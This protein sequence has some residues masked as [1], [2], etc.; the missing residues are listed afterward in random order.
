MGDWVLVGMRSEL[1]PGEYRVVWDDATPIAVYN[2]EGQL[3]AI[4]DQCSHDALELAG[5]ELDGYEVVCPWHG[6]RFDLRTGEAKC[7]PAYEPV[8]TFPVREEE[9]VIWTRDDR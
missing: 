9:G 5:G 2:V 1:L 8:A 3:Y 4:E 6:A 7:A